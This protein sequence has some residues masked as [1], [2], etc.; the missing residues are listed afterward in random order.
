MLSQ[1][2][3]DIVKSTVPVLEQ[4]GKTITTVFYKNMFEAHPELLNIFNHAN[5]S[6]GRQQTALANTVLAA[7]KYIDNLEVIVP[8]V[9]QIAHKHRGLD[10]RPEHYPIVGHHL[11]GAIK[12]VLGDAATPEILNA[13]GE[14]YGVIAD[15]FI[16]V[17]K[18]M[19][20]QAANTENGWD[21]FKD[22]VVAKKVE[23]SDVITSFYLKPADGKGVPGYKP[24]QY[25]TVRVTIPGE[26]YQMIRQ[27]S[28]SRAPQEE[29]FRISVKREDECN[30][31]GKV[32]TFLHRSVN[33]GDIVEASVPAGDFFLDTEAA[34][35]VTL[36][37]GGVGLTPMLAMFDYITSN[38]PER[39]AA[40]I[41]SA[42][43][44][45]LQAFDGDLREMAAG[46]DN[47]TCSVRY[48]DSEGFLD[49][50]FLRSRVIEGSDIYLC[51]PAPFMNAMIHELRAIGVPVEKIHYEF[52]GP[53]AELDAITA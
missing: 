36:I 51:G 13:W 48:S 26:Q 18:N 24:G 50:D 8:A 34:T 30:P 20:E 5:Q 12:E 9:V 35:P 21:G 39:K 11:L 45:Q 16:G 19:Y 10:V 31:E 23:E 17:E 6:R 47:A 41:H 38:Q 4:H 1:Q 42:R 14:A 29:M 44:P 15:A 3:I 46:N 33:V 37:S 27:Y 28:L 53:A 2:T 49:R 43:N 40:F 32:S 25:L 22:F 7:A 52:F